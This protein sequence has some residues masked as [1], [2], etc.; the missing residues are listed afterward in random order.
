MNTELQKELLTS[1]VIKTINDN[2][3]K[4]LKDM[5]R[6]ITDNIKLELDNVGIIERPEKFLE[7]MLK[8][9]QEVYLTNLTSSIVTKLIEETKGTSTT[10]TSTSK[11]KKAKPKKEG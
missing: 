11:P 7:N 3:H 6:R 9:N 5:F 4:Q 1:S 2:A 10:G 8:N